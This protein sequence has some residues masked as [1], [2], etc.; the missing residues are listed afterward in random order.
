MGGN[1]TLAHYAACMYRRVEREYPPAWRVL[2][3]FV[4]APA[5]A[6][7]LMA[8]LMPA[9][10]GLPMPERIWKSAQIYT[11]VG[12][13]PSALIFGLPAYLLLRRHLDPTIVKCM[14]VGASVAALP[15]LILSILPSGATQ[16]SVGGRA[17]VIDGQRTLYGWMLN[18][19]SVLQIAT[20]GAVGGLMFW[21]IVVGQ[22][23]TKDIV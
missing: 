10:D 2:L 11:L 13:Y 17:T 1:R 9:Y 22:R 18:A 12:A 16:E 4:V 5:I 19:E 15:W 20:F 21:L 23:P 8:T 7:L 6:A 14:S 3:G